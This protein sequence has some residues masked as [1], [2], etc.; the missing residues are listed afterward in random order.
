MKCRGCGEEF[1]HLSALTK[2][3]SECPGEV[4]EDAQGPLFIPIELCPEEAKL[5][6]QGQSVAF[7]V[8]GILTP[9][10]IE[11]QEVTLIR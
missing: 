3:K 11:V 2:H 10:G 6:A 1:E 4:V 7:R 5:Y 8:T 9:T